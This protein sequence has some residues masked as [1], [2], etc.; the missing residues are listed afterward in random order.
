MKKYF[1]YKFYLVRIFI[2]VF[3]AYL[4]LITISMI[5]ATTDFIVRIIISTIYMFLSILVG[6]F[7]ARFMGY[8][9]WRYVLSQIAAYYLAT[10]ILA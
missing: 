7:I 3:F 2:G 9:F 6:G 10:V 8:N 5:Y 4:F 1:D